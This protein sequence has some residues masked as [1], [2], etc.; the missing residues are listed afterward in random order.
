MTDI[1]KYLLFGLRRVEGWVDPIAAEFTV[2]LSGVQVR[3]GLS[4]SIGEIGVHHGKYFILLLLLAAQ[5]EHAFAIDVFDEQDQNTDGSGRG[6][7]RIFEENIQRW[8]RGR[9]AVHIIKK[10]SLDVVPDEITRVCGPSRLVSIDGGHTAECAY[11]DLKLIEAVM[12]EHGIAIIDDYFNQD[13]PDVSAGVARYFMEPGTRL[14][15]FV[16][17]TN[18]LFVATP[19]WHDFYR[20]KLRAETEFSHFKQSEMFG[21]TV[22]V[23][24]GNPDAPPL[25]DYVREALRRSW[26][27][28]YLLTLKQ[29]LR[30]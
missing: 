14:R 18:K 15:P 12:L 27:G 5:G 16:I 11:S 29:A 1:G 8:C 10:S 3:A 24:H 7:L 9:P 2:A 25:F 21:H 22:T 28:P 13:W 4:G 19:S 23:Y 20:D 30:G 6:D 17:A 26:L